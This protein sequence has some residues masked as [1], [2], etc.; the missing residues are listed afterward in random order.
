MHTKL[1]LPLNRKFGFGSGMISFN[2]SSD[3]FE[4]RS[5]NAR[6]VETLWGSK[7]SRSI[8]LHN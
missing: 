2:L 4:K 3:F 7:K 5:F 1:M 8:T 6:F